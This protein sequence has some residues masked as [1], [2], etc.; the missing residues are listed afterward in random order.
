MHIEGWHS[1]GG[2]EEWLGAVALG[3][4]VIRNRFLSKIALQRQLVCDGQKE[5]LQSQGRSHVAVVTG[6]QAVIA[7]LKARVAIALTLT[8]AQ[9]HV[10]RHPLID[11]AE[12]IQFR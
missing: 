5:L 12:L 6:K 2:E 9:G 4:R 7:R 8:Q 1:S 3:R 11:D 10:E